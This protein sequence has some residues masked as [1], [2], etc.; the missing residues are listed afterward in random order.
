MIAVPFPSAVVNV[1]GS[2]NTYHVPL[3]PPRVCLPA[4]SH[5]HERCTSSLFVLQQKCARTQSR[6]VGNGP[7]RFELLKR[8]QAQEPSA[9]VPRCLAG[10]IAPPTSI[11]TH[12]GTSSNRRTH[13]HD[14]PGRGLRLR[15]RL[16]PRDAAHGVG[17]A[18]HTFGD[19]PE[20]NRLSTHSLDDR[21]AHAL[22]L[23][24]SSRAVAPKPVAAAPM[25]AAPA[26]RTL[27]PP[28]SL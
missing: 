21:A 23:R 16:G 2:G 20:R 1:I 25:K 12:V 5:G 15:S 13:I 26:E 22:A 27:A 24:Q 18:T 8:L 6:A 19:R 11:A 10:R 9:P 4:Q 7:L 28:L 14:G 3:L 17:G